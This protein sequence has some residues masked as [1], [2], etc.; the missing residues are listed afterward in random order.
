MVSAPEDSLLLVVCYAVVIDE[1]E[2]PCSGTCHM[3]RTISCPKVEVIDV[4]ERIYITETENAI[5][6][7]P[8]LSDDVP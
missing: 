1:M 3:A 7:N 2:C 4:V 8:V 5:R 6:Y